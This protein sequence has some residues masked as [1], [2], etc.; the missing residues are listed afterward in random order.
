MRYLAGPL[1]AGKWTG[2]Q[3]GFGNLPGVVAPYL[4]GVIVQRPGN[5]DYAFLVVAFFLA[6]GV[7]SILFLVGPIQQIEWKT[8]PDM[9]A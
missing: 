1:A 2:L 9:T 8:S 7:G 3:N 4:T 5:Y 6:M